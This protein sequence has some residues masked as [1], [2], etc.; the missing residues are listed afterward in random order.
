MAL[1]FQ[2]AFRTQKAV[3]LVDADPTYNTVLTT[4][5]TSR[6]SQYSPCGRWFAW[7]TPA[8]VTICDA[9]TSKTVLTLGLVNVYELAFS[10]KGSFVST[11]ERPSKD[12]AGDAT[13]N[14][15]VWRVEQAAGDATL[16]SE[17]EPVGQF[18]QKQ[19]EGWNLWYTSDEKYCARQV[20]NEV[21]FYLSDDLKTVSNKLHVE[22]VRQFAL[23]PGPLKSVAV[24]VPQIKVRGFPPLFAGHIP[25]FTAPTLPSRAPVNNP[26]R[27]LL[28][29]S[30]STTPQT[31]R[32]R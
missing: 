29:L 4:D 2:F 12:E 26:N 25:A 10:P 31:S 28:R 15:K 14:L 21:Q 1:P 11:W 3:G 6:Y 7:A 5:V 22:G 13:K 30:R 16:P 19:I 32:A 24:Y 18:V 17:V 20:T 23:A 8:G 9:S 27:A